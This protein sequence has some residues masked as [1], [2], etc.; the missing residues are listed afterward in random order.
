MS[1]LR[2][3]LKRAAQ[4]KSFYTLVIV[5]GVALIAVAGFKIISAQ[6]EYSR[7]RN[8]YDDL[9]SMFY[10]VSTPMM[11]AGIDLTLN[12]QERPTNDADYESEDSSEIEPAPWS[13]PMEELYEIN[14][15]FVGWITIDDMISYPIVQGHNND[16]YLHTTFQGSRNSSGA[17][18]VD[19][20]NR[21]DFLS[22]VTF[23]YGHNMRDGSMFGTLNRFLNSDFLQEN[24]FIT[25]RKPDWTTITYRI[26]AVRVVNVWD[27][28]NNPNN[29]TASTMQNA[30][31][32]VSENTEHF[33]ILS[34]CTFNQNDDERLR[35]Y[36]AM[37]DYAPPFGMSG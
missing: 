17:I 26:F 36:A 18:F 10:A 25:I 27:V 11:D 24:Q 28:E 21:A 16:R 31:S 20:R 23:I 35:V 12:P 4:S 14:S 15:D 29:L 22:P 13:D 3:K 5:L 2:L 19:Y 8:E 37:I 1:N 34:T 7:A 30:F 6:L 32:A 33:L 9:R